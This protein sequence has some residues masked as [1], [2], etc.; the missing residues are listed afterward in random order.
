VSVVCL[1]FCDLLLIL[2][3]VELELATNYMVSLARHLRTWIVRALLA[4]YP[5]L[6]FVKAA[7]RRLLADV[8]SLFTFSIWYAKELAAATFAVYI[9]GESLSKAE[10]DAQQKI[11][12][13]RDG[14]TAWPARAADLCKVQCLCLFAVCLRSADRSRTLVATACATAAQ[15]RR[16]V[17][18]RRAEPGERHHHR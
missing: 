9:T 4:V 2:F 17:A 14:A 7:D 11:T 13:R 18:P 15:R 16:H 10:A 5:P 12:Q 6:P 8:S 1:R 3:I